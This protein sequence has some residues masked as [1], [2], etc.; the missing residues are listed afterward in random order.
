M[1]KGILFTEE[2]KKKYDYVRTT[3]TEMLRKILQDE[4]F[5]ADYVVMPN[6]DEIVAV[7]FNNKHSVKNIDVTADSLLAL[8]RD[9][10]KH[11]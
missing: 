3:L 4:R 6:G 9:V 11:F 8:T 1:A 10:L 5:C 2:Q 7:S